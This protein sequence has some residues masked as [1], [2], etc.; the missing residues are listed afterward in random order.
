MT[1]AMMEKR[2]ILKARG[3]V[4]GFNQSLGIEKKLGPRIHIGLELNANWIGYQPQKAWESSKY[5]L[6]STLSRTS[7]S[8]IA[9]VLDSVYLFYSPYRELRKGALCQ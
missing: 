1:I 6:P 8:A 7:P 4:F 3:K 5:G 2:T 9:V